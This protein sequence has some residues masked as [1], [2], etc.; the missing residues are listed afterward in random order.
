MNKRIN[1]VPN[2]IHKEGKLFIQILLIFVAVAQHK[3]VT[4]LQGF[5]KEMVIDINVTTLYNN[6]DDF[7]QISYV[8][9]INMAVL[10]VRV[11]R[12][13]CFDI[14]ELNIDKQLLIADQYALEQGFTTDLFTLFEQ[15]GESMN[16]IEYIPLFFVLVNVGEA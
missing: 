5:K 15:M 14:T 16:S 9:L 10:G 2:E 1:N 4:Q 3:F 8:C 11:F 13:N 7:G 12:N 6:D